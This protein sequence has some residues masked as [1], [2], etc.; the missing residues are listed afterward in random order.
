MDHWPKILI[1]TPSLNQGK[2]I[3]QTIDSVLN[4][5]YPN[6]EYIVVD[7]GSTDET[8]EVL[9]S[10]GDKF[11][12]ISEKDQGQSDAINKGFNMATG[13][14]LAFINS[15]DYYMPNI[16]DLVARTF[17]ETHCD[18]VSGD[19]KIVDPS[20][21]SIQSYIVIYKEILRKFSSKTLFYVANYI[22]QPSTFWTRKVWCS[23][24]PMDT[25]LDYS[26]DYDFFVK[27]FQIS[28][29]VILNQTLSAF[30]IHPSAKGNTHY[31]KQ[32]DL[33]LQILKRYCDNQV[34]ITAHRLHNVMIKLAYRFL[35]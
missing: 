8:L 30:R 24:G 22:I 33:G 4:Q 29:P 2:F 3:R 17:M 1:I 31:V 13:D 34:I 23:A 20:G 35:K 21:R 7:G 19:Y 25:N 14:I 10:Y 5:N 6:L 27:A 9:K 12:W 18:W 32:F 11:L 16:L 28:K 26:M 15:D